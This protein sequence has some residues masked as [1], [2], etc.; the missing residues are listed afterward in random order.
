MMGIMARYADAWNSDRRNDVDEL[1]DIQAR[2]D[3]AWSRQ[4]EIPP[5]S[6][7]WWGSRWMCWMSSGRRPPRQY[8]KRFWPYSGSAEQ[9]AEAI[10]GYSRAHVD[11]M[12]VWIDPVSVEGVEAFAPVLELLDRG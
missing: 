6:S 9:I 5:R 2:V 4:G 11:H 3:A 8:I 10:V 1:L 12:L 7:A